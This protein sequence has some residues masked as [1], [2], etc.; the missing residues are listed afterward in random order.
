MGL[1][2][3]HL[4]NPKSNDEENIHPD[5]NFAREAMQLFSI[6]LYELNPNGTRKLDSF[7]Q[8]VPTYGQTQI[9]EFAKIWTGLGIS[10]VLPNMYTDEPYFGLGIYGSDLTQPMKMYEE[11]HESGEK[12]LLGGFTVPAG[13]TGMEDIEDAIDNLF[14][15]PNVGP[16]IGRRLIQRMVKSNPSPE[17]IERVTRAFND[18]GQGERGDMKAVIKTILL[19][20]EARS[21]EWISDKSQGMLR[22]PMIRYTNFARGTAIEQY[23]GR[24]WN[25][26]YQFWQETGQLVFGFS[27]RI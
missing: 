23:Y 8:D 16:F 20:D 9:K 1:Y 18:N 15:H 24:L 27:Q 25:N 21:C 5:E 12:E 3:S 4:N 13:Q 19:D 22:E 11:E 7:G 17:Y 10:K 26:G 2:L 14:N 6:G